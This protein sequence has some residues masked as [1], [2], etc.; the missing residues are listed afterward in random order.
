MQRIIDGLLYDTETANLIHADGLNERH[1][2]ITANGRFF[3]FYKNGE[4]VAKD[5]NSTKKYLSKYNTEKYIE[6]FG[7]VEEA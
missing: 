4:I 7:N 2:Y 5:E 1:L 6:L 3:M